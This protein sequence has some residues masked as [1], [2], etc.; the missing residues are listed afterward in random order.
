MAAATPPGALA[1]SARLQ[2]PFHVEH[3]WWRQGPTLHELGHPRGDTSS[4]SAGPQRCASTVRPS[5][6]ASAGAHRS[7]R[8]RPF[9]CTLPATRR[10]LWRYFASRGRG[11]NGIQHGGA[12]TPKGSLPPRHPRAVVDFAAAR[13]NVILRW[14]RVHVA[15]GPPFHVE[16]CGR[17]R[18]QPRS[19]ETR[20]PGA[21]VDGRGVS[22]PRPGSSRPPRERRFRGGPAGQTTAPCRRSRRTSRIRFC[23]SAG[24]T[25]GTL[26]A[27]AR[28]PGRTFASF[29]RASADSVRSSG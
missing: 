15:M 22:P 2:L 16:P 26:P 27:C 3:R 12:C 18:G 1:P 23:R 14:Q 9:A 19:D 29:S 6:G 24:D 13:P 7:G 21:A 20:G 10:V 11:A 8:S 28:V 17:G 25:P 5:A 4:T